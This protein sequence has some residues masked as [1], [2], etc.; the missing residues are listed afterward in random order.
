M[1]AEQIHI[2]TTFG[3]NVV[4]KDEYQKGNLEETI[5]SFGILLLQRFY[6]KAETE[7][8]KKSRQVLPIFPL[9]PDHPCFCF[10]TELRSW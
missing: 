2:N 5:E 3:Y 8:D 10:Y 4:S 6:S 7:F 9:M 1:P